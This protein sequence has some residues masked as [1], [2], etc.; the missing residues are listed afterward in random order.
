MHEAEV[1]VFAL[2]RFLYDVS[3]STTEEEPIGVQF[4]LGSHEDKLWPWERNANGQLVIRRDYFERGM[5][6]YLDGL[7]YFRDCS[8][9][10]KRRSFQYSHRR[11]GID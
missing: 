10:F 9:K 2:T 6:V 5:V 11:L 4:Y 3:S 8:A 1:K 7:G